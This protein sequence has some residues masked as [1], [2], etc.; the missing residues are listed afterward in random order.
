MLNQSIVPEAIS[1]AE[2][3]ETT[4]GGQWLINNYAAFSAN[5]LSFVGLRFVIFNESTMATEVLITSQVTSDQEAVTCRVQIP[6]SS[7]KLVTCPVAVNSRFFTITTSRRISVLEFS[8]VSV[9]LSWTEVASPK[10]LVTPGRGFNLK[11]SIASYS[12]TATAFSECGLEIRPSAPDF[13]AVLKVS[14]NFQL[15]WDFPERKVTTVG[16]CIIPIFNT[17]PQFARISVEQNLN[18]S[19][20]LKE[21]NFTDTAWVAPSGLKVWNV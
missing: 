19:L 16:Y 13:I 4:K 9:D 20:E 11:K 10:V 3:I 6:P 8:G 5:L 1:G 2:Y 7:Y 17:V 21:F 14:S 12:I 15:T 18:A